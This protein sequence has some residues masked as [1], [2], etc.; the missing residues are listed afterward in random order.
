[1]LCTA[2][3]VCRHGHRIRTCVACAVHLDLS[4]PVNFDNERCLFSNLAVKDVQTAVVW[5]LPLLFVQITYKAIT[6]P[7]VGFTHPVVQANLAIA[8]LHLVTVVRLLK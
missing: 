4:L 1:M 6:G 5:A 7:I 3:G 2:F 8:A